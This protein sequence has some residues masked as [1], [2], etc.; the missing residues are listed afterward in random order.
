LGLTFEGADTTAPALSITTSKSSLAAGETATL[1]LTFSEAPVGFDKSD[2]AIE[3]GSLGTLTSS[4]DARVFTTTYTPAS[5]IQDPAMLISVAG[6]SY[7]DAAGNSGTAT[8]LNIAVDT[9]GSPSL[10]Y[11]GDALA[12]VFTASSDGS[13]TISGLG[14]NDVLTGAGGAD[15]ISGGDNDDRLA[16]RGGADALDGGAGIDTVVLNGARGDYVFDYVGGKLTVHDLRAGAPDGVDTLTGIEKLEFTGGATKPS[17]AI[18]GSYASETFKATTNADLFLFDT[19]LG[20]S[21]GTDA[22]SGFGAG[23]RFATTSK[24]YDSDNDGRI[25]ANGSDRFVLPGTT[26]GPSSESTGTLKLVN[27]ASK[28]ITN[29]SFLGEQQ[30]HGVTYY[31]YGAATDT[32]VDGLVAF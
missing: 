19:A 27:S 15:L 30:D 18:E 1:T 5:G 11:T 26:T 2:I 21:L 31:V 4:A 20:L 24:I 9:T 7:A 3:S 16:G 10:A 28:P 6:G 17:G 14:G 12:N 25:R 22:I 8:S 29:I 32:T 13:W 23:D